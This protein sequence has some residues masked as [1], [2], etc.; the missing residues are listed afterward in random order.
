MGDHRCCVIIGVAQLCAPP[1]CSKTGSHILEKILQKLA[2]DAPAAD[3]AT[4]TN[5]KQVNAAPCFVWKGM[6]D[7][8]IQSAS[9]SQVIVAALC[10]IM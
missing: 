3:A 2:D 5:V 6:P 7:R 10:N 9:I 1:V 4:Q 8:A